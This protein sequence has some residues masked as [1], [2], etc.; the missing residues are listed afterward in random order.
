MKFH[1]RILLALGALGALAALLALAVPS[2]RATPIFFNGS[3]YEFVSGPA[4]NHNEAVAA[5]SSHT[6]LGQQG[7]LATITSAAEN[8]FVQSLGGGWLGGSRT[9]SV[10]SWDTG[11]GAFWNGA[12]GGS[13]TG[14]YANWDVA[15]PNNSGGGE[16]YLLMRPTGRWQD[17]NGTGRD[18]NYYVVEYNH[19]PV[20]ET[21]SLAS[22]GLGL[23]SL[24]V[25]RR[26]LLT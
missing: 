25:L 18:V 8:A 22:F 11:E 1:P 10:W 9:G 3:Y 24:A 7:H 2:A 21:A 17:Y 13:P 6:Y 23:L 20:P 26:R 4:V 15:E 12:S 14:L 19:V 16:P 5:A